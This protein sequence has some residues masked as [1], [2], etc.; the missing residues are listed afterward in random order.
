MGLGVQTGPDLRHFSQKIIYLFF[1]RVREENPS[2]TDPLLHSGLSWEPGKWH[3]APALSTPTLSA[4]QRESW[5]ASH[6]HQAKSLPPRCLAAAPTHPG[7]CKSCF[8]R[9]APRGAILVLMCFLG[10]SRG[11]M[12]F[13]SGWDHRDLE[14]LIL[15][16]LMLTSFQQF[17]LLPPSASGNRNQEFDEETFGNSLAVQGL[18]L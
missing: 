13:F 15:S 7:P 6:T 1:P 11:S 2:R 10:I 4:A 5:Q 14:K 12:N 8:A 16:Y 9:V 17:L 3:R 18:G